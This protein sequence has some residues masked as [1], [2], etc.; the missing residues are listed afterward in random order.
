MIK[1]LNN[2]KVAPNFNLDEFIC[3]CGCNSLIYEPELVEKLQ[4]VRNAI[5]GPITIASGYRCE[6]HNKKVG[7]DPNSRHIKGLAAD[8]KS[9]KNIWEL[10]R[11]CYEAG[12]EGIGVS[13]NLNTKPVS[14]YYV[15]V[16]VGGERKFWTYDNY[17]K[18]HR[19]TED[20]FLRLIGKKGY[21][22]EKISL[23]HIIR[24][25]PMDLRAEIVNKPPAKIGHKTFWNAN[26]FYYDNG[27]PRVVGWLISEG[28][29][30]NERHVDPKWDKPKGTF[31]VYKD[32]KV[33]ASWKTDTEM[34]KL[35]PNI[36]F[37]CQGFNL[38]PPGMT[39][40]EGIAK[41]GFNYAE[42]GYATNRIAM[43]YD[44]KQ[45][46]AIARPS[47]NAERA[48]ESLK[49]LGC[50]VGIGLDSGTPATFYAGETAHMASKNAIQAIVFVKGE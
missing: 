32:G 45:V 49:N 17:N 6:S 25:N 30:L 35:A 38:F 19:I 46:V 34:T 13:D 43:G 16:Q 41:E 47:T 21:T 28:K 4:K 10:A 7:G 48:Q 31:I 37:A 11:A 26:Y 8:I 20:E 29:I 12:F 36:W 15:H 18:S 5:G 27:V 50:N 44:G 23:T 33:D 39:V 42:I 40:K 24:C 3:K 1:I 2:P 14:G 22:Y 9:S